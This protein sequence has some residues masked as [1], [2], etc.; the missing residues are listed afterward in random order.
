MDH[1]NG[2][3]LVEFTSNL[4]IYGAGAVTISDLKVFGGDSGYKF[5]GQLQRAVDGSL[6]GR[7]VIEQHQQGAA[8]V[9]NTFGKFNLQVTG[10]VEGNDVRLS[11]RVVGAEHM[12]ISIVA[13]RQAYDP[14]RPDGRSLREG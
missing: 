8:S 6:S 3:Y 1:L 2:N 11:G 10:F 9:F 5:S 13:H 7:L 14:G 12:M 4:G